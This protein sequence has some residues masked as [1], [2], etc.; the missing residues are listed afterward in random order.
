MFAPRCLVCVASVGAIYAVGEKI[1]V[2]RITSGKRG[3][4]GWVE[5]AN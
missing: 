2:G 1:V 5:R 4:R 3:P